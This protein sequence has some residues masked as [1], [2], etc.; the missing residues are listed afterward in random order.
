MGLEIYLGCPECKEYVFMGKTGGREQHHGN[1]FAFI[2]E[3][4]CHTL[5][6]FTDGDGSLLYT[7]YKDW[8]E[9]KE[10]D[11]GVGG[12]MCKS[13]MQC[14]EYNTRCVLYEGHD[15]LHRNGHLA[16]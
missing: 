15:G 14:D 4:L 7:T 6:G 3:H 16:W 12:Y 8:T 2:E 13:I 11:D 1:L 9:F 5:V 10:K